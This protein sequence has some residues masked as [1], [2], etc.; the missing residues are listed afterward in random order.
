MGMF[1]RL[2]VRRRRTI[3]L[4]THEEDIAAYAKRIVRLLRRADRHR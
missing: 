2:N 1:T 3:I 4:I